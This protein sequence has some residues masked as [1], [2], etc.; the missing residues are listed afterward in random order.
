[1]SLNNLQM[2]INAV[3]NGKGTILKMIYLHGYEKI[4]IFT[5]IFTRIKD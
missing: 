4:T 1:M 3:L 2:A 5:E